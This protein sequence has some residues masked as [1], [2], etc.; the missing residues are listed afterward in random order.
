M[1]QEPSSHPPMEAPRHD[2]PILQGGATETDTSCAPW[3]HRPSPQLS[4]ATLSRALSQEPGAE[5]AVP[6]L[7]IPAEG[8][9]S[10]QVPASVP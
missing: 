7:L 2:G 5:A 10:R 1:P 3:T 4:W 9:E 6:W 8:S